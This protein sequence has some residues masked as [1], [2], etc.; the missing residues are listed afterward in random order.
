MLPIKKI[1][2]KYKDANRLKVKMDKLYH[3]KMNQM[4]TGGKV[5][6]TIRNIK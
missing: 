5:H 3:A 1:H 4:K 6:F 2:F